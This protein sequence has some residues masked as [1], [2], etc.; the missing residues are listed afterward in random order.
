MGRMANA[1]IPAKAGSMFCL[2]DMDPAFAGMTVGVF[3]GIT[4]CVRCQT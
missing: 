4:V 2:P 1:V 3:A